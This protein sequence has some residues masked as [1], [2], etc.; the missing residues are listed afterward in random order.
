MT[1]DVVWMVFA[2]TDAI[3]ASYLLRSV[4]NQRIKCAS[5]KEWKGVEGVVTHAQDPRAAVQYV[6]DLAPALLTDELRLGACP[7]RGP[8]P[9]LEAARVPALKLVRGC[10]RSCA[11]L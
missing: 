3:F 2:S 11:P 10:H 8:L 9:R 4:E 1:H 5:A 7:A 6:A